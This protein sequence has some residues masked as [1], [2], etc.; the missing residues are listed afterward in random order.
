MWCMRVLAK[1]SVTSN[2]RSRRGRGSHRNGKTVILFLL[3]RV[4]KKM[5]EHTLVF[6]RIIIYQ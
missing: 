3:D 1:R 2:T 5:F 4:T 6:Q